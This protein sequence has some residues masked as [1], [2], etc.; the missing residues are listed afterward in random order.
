[1]PSFFVLQD[2]DHAQIRTHL[3]DDGKR[4]VW[5]HMKPCSDPT[6][7]RCSCPRALYMMQHGSVSRLDGGVWKTVF[8]KTEYTNAMLRVGKIIDDLPE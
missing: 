5:S 1:M 3:V 2:A 7:A 8:P 6:A 4:A